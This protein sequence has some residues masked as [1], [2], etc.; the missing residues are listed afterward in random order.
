MKTDDLIH[1]TKAASL[2]GRGPRSL[3]G[4]YGYLSKLWRRVT[5]E[6]CLAKRKGSH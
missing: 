1:K 5:C 2:N 3:C 4:Q 6:I